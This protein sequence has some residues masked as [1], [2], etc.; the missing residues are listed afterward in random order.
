MI[1]S[2]NDKFYIKNGFSFLFH[3]SFLRYTTMN[4]VLLYVLAYLCAYSSLAPCYNYV[5]FIA[6]LVFVLLCCEMFCFAAC[7]MCFA[8][9]H[10]ICP[11]FQQILVPS[12]KNS[13]S[14]GNLFNKWTICRK[15]VWLEFSNHFETQLL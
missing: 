8:F 3:I 7:M 13:L 15:Q 4:C 1:W 5:K 2:K 10:T 14:C 11:I 12:P 9:K 6:L